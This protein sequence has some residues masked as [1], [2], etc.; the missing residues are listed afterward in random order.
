MDFMLCFVCKMDC[1]HPL[2]FFAVLFFMRGSLTLMLQRRGEKCYALWKLPRWIKKS[3]ME[4][5]NGWAHIKIGNG[6]IYV[7]YTFSVVMLWSCVDN[8]CSLFSFS[9]LF[10][11]MSWNKK[12]ATVCVFLISMNSIW[13]FNSRGI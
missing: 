4:M 9:F 8:I 3:K 1:G 12:M 7:Y 2:L 13:T 5:G 6:Y 11:L 10:I